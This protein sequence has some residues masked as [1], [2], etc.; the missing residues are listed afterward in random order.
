MNK[1]INFY[2]KESGII[3]LKLKDFNI[4]YKFFKEN[5]NLIIKQINGDKIKLKKNYIGKNG[6]II[7]YSIG[8]SKC[9]KMIDFWTNI[10]I[11]YIYSFPIYSVNCDNIIDNNDYMLPLLKIMEY[12]FYV[13]FDKNGV[14]EKFN[15][16]IT[17]ENVLY[18]ISNN[19]S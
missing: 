9:K 5:N 15:T 19:S 1:I 11:N 16:E 8:C 17:L 6:I 14:I 4:K 10:A 12:P 13:T 18:Y 7:F 2:G 3:E